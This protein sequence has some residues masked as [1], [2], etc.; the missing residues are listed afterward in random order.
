MHDKLFEHQRNLQR[1]DLIR[2]GKE[3]GLE[4]GAFTECLDSGRFAA[5]WK[6]DVEEGRR[7]GVTGTP[8]FFV[9]G[10]LIVGT[11][12]AAA[13]SEVIDEELAEGASS[14]PGRTD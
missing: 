3:V 7:Y 14:P 4:R 2:Y 9:N 10:R 11:V 5:E 13:F 8:T 6:L 1:E 12:P